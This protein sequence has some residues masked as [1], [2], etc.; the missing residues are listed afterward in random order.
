MSLNTEH[1]ARC[2]QTLEGSLDRLNQVEIGTLEYEIYRN[3][4]VKGFELT[5]ETTG[6]LLRKALKAYTGRPR[7]MDLLTFKEVLRHATKHGLLSPEAVE[8]WYAY[9]DNRNTTAHD[10]GEAFAEET[11]VL[12]PG[13]ILDARALEVALRTRLGDAEA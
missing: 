8:R 1:L 6:K 7:E 12:L 5:L 9:R 11:L 3:A 2:I 10:Y 13:F 4:V